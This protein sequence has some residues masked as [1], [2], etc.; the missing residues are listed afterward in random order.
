MMSYLISYTYHRIPIL[1]ACSLAEASLP[2]A[3][4]SD[5]SD[6]SNDQDRQMDPEVACD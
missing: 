6:G 4:R 2:P 3:K 5:A 1:T